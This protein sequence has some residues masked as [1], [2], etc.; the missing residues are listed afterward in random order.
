MTEPFAHMRAQLG[1]V[2]EDNANLCEGCV[3]DL[4]DDADA[5]LAMVPALKEIANYRYGG[6][7]PPELRRIAA[8]ALDALP[9]H[10]THEHDWID[11][12]NEYVTGGSV[13][14]GCG[15]IRA[16]SPEQLR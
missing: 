7:T 13:C 11:P 9:E 3:R 15:E 14:L 6:D 5:L 4:L 8:E 1:P 2:D 12:T 10:L 16:E